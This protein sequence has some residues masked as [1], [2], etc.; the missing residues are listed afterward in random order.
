MKTV[1]DFKTKKA[2]R[3]A[4]ERGDKIKTT[5]VVNGYDTIQKWSQRVRV[6]NSIIMEMIR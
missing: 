3:T 4:F 2:L 5:G 1:R 6:E